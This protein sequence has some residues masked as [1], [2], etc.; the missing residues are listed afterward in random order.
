MV[1]YK[2]LMRLLTTIYTIWWIVVLRAS[3]N[4]KWISQTSHVIVASL[5]LKRFYFDVLTSFYGI[6]AKYNCALEA[7]DA[8]IDDDRDDMVDCSAAG[9][10]ASPNLNQ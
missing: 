5:L 6:A 9:Q 10:P 3:P 1:L 8:V 7:A 4:P 2:L